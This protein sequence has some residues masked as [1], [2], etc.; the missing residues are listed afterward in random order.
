M[1]ITD[2]LF[3]D[4]NVR[5][6][7]NISEQTSDEVALATYVKNKVEESRMS[8]SRITHEG[9]WMTNIAYV[10][11]FDGVFY[12]TT[13][14]QFR[15]VSKGS[16]TVRRSRVHV[17][18]ILPSVQNRLA[19]LCKNPPKYDVR[20]N[21]SNQE[22]KDAAR[23]GLQVLNMVWDM[24]NINEKRLDLFMWVQQCGHAYGKI[25]WDTELG[26][27]MVDPQTG[28]L[29]YEGDIRFDVVSPFEV[30]VDPIAT[31]MDEARWLVQAKVRKLDYFR[32]HYPEKGDLVKEE[33][34]WLL[35][36]QYEMRINSL[37]NRGQGQTG[38]QTIMKNSAIELAYYEKRSKKHP[39]GRMIIVANGVLLADK[40][41]PVGE[42]PF[43]KFDDVKV[44]GKFFSESVITHA[45]PIQDQINRIISLRAN[46][47]NKLLA[48]KYISPK[49]AGLM[50]E[51]LNDQSG[52]VVEYDPV[53]NAAPPQA[54]PVPSIPQY[55]YTE[56]KD[57]LEHL[58]DIF[59]INEI[60]RGQLP[61]AGIPAVGMQFL[62]EQDETRIGVVTESNEHGFAKIGQL[63]LMYAQ[64]FYI[65][66]RLLKEA[67][68]NFEYRVKEFIG[69]DL[70]DNHDVIV[71]RGSTL[72]GSKVLKRQE[73]LNAYQQGLLGDPQDP[74]VRE[75]VFGH[76]EFG[77]IAE[78]W[79]D[80]ALDMAQ[81]HKQITELEQGIPQIVSELDNHQLHIS[82][83]NKYRKSEKFDQLAD[84]VKK[85]F[86]D[87]IE[88]HIQMLMHM[89][90]PGLQNN[91]NAL[92]QSVDQLNQ[93]S[94]QAD[95]AHAAE[96][97]MP[98]EP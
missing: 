7:S 41:L 61:A 97:M 34:A 33:G 77:D 74:K 96:G 20:P 88:K 21:S 31:N 9:I 4:N 1:G 86:L 66:P 6:E 87:D 14:R 84:P 2:K 89:M 71:V 79:D 59:G 92:N 12:D 29:D 32:T 23:L 19:R 95:N 47:T 49:G 98:N 91:I 93:V 75:K 81:I 62:Q 72:P 50:Q 39:N 64:K 83:K 70:K 17:N 94:Q 58:Y 15:T 30:F 69:A 56:E 37:N 40:E 60:S 76:L 10:L 55:A 51:A 44:G 38:S 26:K 54:L 45:R 25:S 27:P 48:G 82:E 52:E 46:W 24:Q 78:M 35:S 90:N 36:T 13:L 85:L 16:R 3:G 43:V 57:L 63:I 22:D 53:P 28:E 73:I 5:P 65:T 8:S 67:G 80:Y 42:I 11:G 18:K 68:R